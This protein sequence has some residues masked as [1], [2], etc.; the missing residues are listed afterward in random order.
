MASRPLIALAAGLSL[1]SESL[2]QSANETVWASFAYVLYGERTPFLGDLVSSLTPLGAQQLYSQGSLFRARYL[3]NSS[4][5]DEDN[6]ITTN[7]PIVGLERQALDNSQLSVF[8]STDDYVVGGALAF[9]Q[10][11]YPP[12]TRAFADNNGG[13]N[14]SRLANGTLVNYPLGG[15][16]Y[17]NIR[18][19]PT[20]DPNS[21]W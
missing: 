1:V 18:N 21:I 5:S 12:V 4:L 2:A 16:Q 20:T 3:S 6:A 14:A 19:V 8:S 9:L 10:G 13:A 17:P 15:Y 11:L 7:S